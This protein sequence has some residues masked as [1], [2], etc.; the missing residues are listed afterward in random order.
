M[1]VFRRLQLGLACLL[2]LAGCA[3]AELSEEGLTE[4]S[5]TVGGVQRAYLVYH[6]TTNGA[7]LPIIFDLHGWGDDAA[8]QFHKTGFAAIAREEGAII[9]YPQTTRGGLL[10]NPEADLAY[11]EA[12]LDATLDTYPADENRVYVTGFSA[13]GFAAHYAGAALSDRVTAVATV[14]GGLPDP[15]L[16]NMGGLIDD[17][18]DIMEPRMPPTP[19]RPVPVMMLHGLHDEVVPYAV[20][21]P[22]LKHWLGWNNCDKQPEIA[23]GTDPQQETYSGCDGGAQVALVP[24]DDGHI[25]PLEA[26]WLDA[27]RVMWHFLRGY[28]L[29][30]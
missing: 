23:E 26:D 30:E 7:D 28:S 27:S 13:G 29:N 17:A 5:V 11:F 10:W 22:S 25:Y 14:S 2:V 6:P 4:H 18:Y 9:I 16:A 19:T 3:T 24:F 8:D 1:G 15:A 21:R 12:M 20:V